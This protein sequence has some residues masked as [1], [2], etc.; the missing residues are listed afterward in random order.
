MNF[1]FLIYY[2]F[3]SGTRKAQKKEE[4]EALKGFYNNK[5]IFMILVNAN[6]DSSIYQFF[7]VN[8]NI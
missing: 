2:T 4:K 7:S 5:L 3:R 8:N 6:V 1:E